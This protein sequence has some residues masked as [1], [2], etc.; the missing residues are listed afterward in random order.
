MN[1]NIREIYI[2]NG[3]I[4]PAEFVITANLLQNKQILG[5]VIANMASYGY[6][7]SANVLNTLFEMEQ[8]DIIAFWTAYEPVFK[9]I[10]GANRSMEKFVVYKN[11]PAEVLNMSEAEY[12][13]NQILMYLGAP[14]QL[15]T[16]D[17]QSRPSMLESLNL[18]VLDLPK[19][20]TLD[21]IRKNLIALPTRWS[22][23]QVN[24]MLALYQH[25]MVGIDVD[26][27]G[28]K[29]NAISLIA[30][31]FAS[32][33]GFFSWKF[34][35]ATDILRLCAALSEQD[36]SLRETVKFTNFRRSERRR[37]IELLN[38]C[39]NLKEDFAR[40]PEIWKRLLSRLHPGDFPKNVNV[41][42]AYNDLYNKITKTLASEL[43]NN[44]T[45]VADNLLAHPGEFLRRFHSLYKK[46]YKEK[47]IIIEMFVETIPK[48]TTIQLAKI[49]KYLQTIN[50]RKTL[51]V[52]PK[53]NWSKAKIFENNKIK[54]DRSDFMLV[55]KAIK[56]ELAGRMNNLFPEGI[57][58]DAKLSQVK[59]QTNDQKLAEYGRGTTF[60]I[61][62]NITFIRS[63]SYWEQMGYG[64]NTWFDNGWNFFDENWKTVG[65]CSWNC[66]HQVK[67]SVFSGD[68]TNSKELKG[69]GCQMIDLYFDKLPSNVRYAVWNVLCYSKIKFCDAKDVLATLQMGE[70]PETGKLYEPARA[71]MVFPLK[72]NAL[73]KYVAYIDVKERKLV[74]MD[75]N[76]S[77][78]T[79]AATYNAKVLQGIMPAY[80]EYLNSLPSVHDLVRYCKK[81]ET[82]FLFKDENI[83]IN[84]EQA[85]VFRPTNADNIFKRIDINSLLNKSKTA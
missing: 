78:N 64:R 76:F 66:T 50:D 63:A 28:F 36:V 1:A 12:W 39:K 84:N 72:D 54:I 80:V 32:N 46:Y 18:K 49:H 74:Y 61:P 19:I 7:P 62:E 33:F 34:S 82:P 22:D 85:Y 6:A 38:N 59:L 68:P 8:N 55:S 42:R 3:Y 44:E 43:E 17:E 47:D 75:A 70:N 77:G 45:F 51:I 83:N 10:T 81:G 20:G 37:I 65:T 48:L 53:G 31:L 56:D 24:D 35:N 58:L 15:F 69:R 60:D 2:R 79:Q 30:K 9:K 16:Q 4:N 41:I 71:Q 25:D 5:T 14:N 13:V 11:F 73:T 29:E 23:N 27:F 57:N 40:R 67:G 52:P 21:N 26:T